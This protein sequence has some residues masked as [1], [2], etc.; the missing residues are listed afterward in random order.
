M[1]KFATLP[2]KTCIGKKLH[3]FTPLR[4]RQHLQK[5]STLTCIHETFAQ[6]THLQKSLVFTQNSD[7]L[8]FFLHL[9]NSFAWRSHE[10]LSN[11]QLYRS[12]S[13]HL[14][15]RNALS[16]FAIT[17]LTLHIWWFTSEIHTTHIYISHNLAFIQNSPICT[18]PS[19]FWL[20]P[21]LSQS[22]LFY[23]SQTKHTGIHTNCSFV[24]S[25][26]EPAC[27]TWLMRVF[28]SFFTIAVMAEML[29]H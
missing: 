26:I 13:H 11:V 12:Y 14:H 20:H 29:S 18:K 2:Y 28:F 7:S 23:I 15:Y 9:R 24:C 17:T 27:T 19:H 5:P 21:S 1:L 6:N 4:F 25:H 3:Y 8:L 22:V 16:A 10:A